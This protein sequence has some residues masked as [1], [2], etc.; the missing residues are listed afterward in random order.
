MK[1][2]QIQGV[3]NQLIDA[4]A[5]VE[6]DVGRTGSGTCT[7]RASANQ[8]DLWFFLRNWF[9]DGSSR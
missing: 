2:K 4:L 1:K 5:A 6:H 9:S 3:L 7:A 8:T